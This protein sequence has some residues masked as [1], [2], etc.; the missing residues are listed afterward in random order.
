MQVI[1]KF[2]QLHEVIMTNSTQLELFFILYDGR[3]G[4]TMLA[5]QIAKR[6]G[7]VVIPETNFITRLLNQSKTSL[8]SNHDLITIIDY[9]FE[10]KKFLDLQIYKRQLL[11][12]LQVGMSIK[13]VILTILALYYE[14]NN[15]C[16]G[17]IGIKKGSYL[18]KID[19]IMNF[20]PKAHLFCLV[21]DGRAVFNSKRRN[22]YNETNKAFTKNPIVAAN[23]WVKRYQRIKTAQAKYGACL[24]YYE[25]MIQDIDKSINKIAQQLGVSETANVNN[26]SG[27]FVPERFNKIH[28]NINKAPQI[29]NIDKWKSQ[30]PYKDIYCFEKIAYN[31]LLEAGYPLFSSH[32]KLVL[33]SYYYFMLLRNKVC[34]ILGL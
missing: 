26:E 6:L 25:S 33:S 32:K 27:Y 7:I 30:L 21:R 8:A 10:E 20:F 29:D 31:C 22:L 23:Q 15:G 1:T 24:F 14:N 5:N 19:E 2:N 13:D 4:S 34:K 18:S 17:L 9:L 28:Q 16:Y 3:S 11:D 12:H